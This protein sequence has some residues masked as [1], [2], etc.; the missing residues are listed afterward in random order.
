[1]AKHLPGLPA[2]G[3]SSVEPGRPRP[4]HE[5]EPHLETPFDAAMPMTP[6]ELAS[7]Q[8]ARVQDTWRVFRIMGEFVE[9]FERLGQI[10]PSVSVFG[11]ART[12]PGHPYYAMGEAVGR[13]LVERGFAVITGGGPGIME[14]A[15]KGAQAAGGASVGLN[16][17]LPHEQGS[18][19]FVD[20]D[21][22]L[23]FDFF[24]ARKTMFVRYAQGFVVLPGG[25]GTMDELFEALTLIQ[26]HKTE[27]FP[28]VLMGAAF[29]GGLVGW[30][31]ETMLAAGNIAHPDLA[32]FEVTDDPG[33]AVAIIE[34]YSAEVGVG[35]N[36]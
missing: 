20:A 18:N 25:Y 21:K 13:R 29:W 5:S 4:S 27:R 22:N 11:S 2:P 16:I 17:A 24:F 3:A 8:A 6:T 26:T 14:A 15:N 31:R 32:L 19:P 10:G 33:E 23:T 7:W 1:M 30:L 35:P 12:P 36:F 9:G 34:R 28:V